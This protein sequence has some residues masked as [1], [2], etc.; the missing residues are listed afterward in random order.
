[1]D[2]IEKWKFKL[3]GRG[4]RVIRVEEVDKDGRI[5]V[6]R[7]VGKLKRRANS[8]VEAWD[9]KGAEI[10]PKNGLIQFISDDEIVEPAYITFKGQTVD[11]VGEKYEYGAET[12]DIFTGIGTSFCNDS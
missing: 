4:I 5:K 1:M 7:I 3:F 11:V 9:Q 12:K 10:N 6:L 2:F 8:L